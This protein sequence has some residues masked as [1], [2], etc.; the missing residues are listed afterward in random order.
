MGEKAENP[1][2]LGQEGTSQ[3]RFLVRRELLGK[4]DVEIDE[5][6]ALA[7]GVVQRRH[8]L[9]WH[10]FTV[11]G[12][13][14]QRK[15]AERSGGRILMQERQLPAPM[16][17]RAEPHSCFSHQ[18]CSSSFSRWPVPLSQPRV[19]TALVSAP[20]LA[21]AS[22]PATKICRKGSSDPR[23]IGPT[24]LTPRCH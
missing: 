5:E 7:L 23:G 17:P 24:A 15:G 20:R 11:F 18:L 8:P 19:P 16:R 14:K 21:R 1:R 13:E 12:A 22:H 3:E 4:A 10:H 9:P 2:P 6:V